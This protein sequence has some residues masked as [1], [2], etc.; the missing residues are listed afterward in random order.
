MRVRTLAGKMIVEM[1]EIGQLKRSS[2]EA[3]KAFVSATED[4]YRPSYGRHEIACKRQ[5]TF[6]GTTNEFAYLKDETG[7]RRFLPVRWG[8]S[9]LDGR[10]AT[11]PQLYAEALHAW[12]SGERWL[13]LAEAMASCRAATARA[14]C[15]GRM[16][17]CREHF[18]CDKEADRAR[19]RRD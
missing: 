19:M 1:P 16:D 5:C 8:R 4:K 6:I 14:H 13:D 18:R 2:V 12:R 7:N 9:I 17:I 10:K 11:M 15:R 3:T